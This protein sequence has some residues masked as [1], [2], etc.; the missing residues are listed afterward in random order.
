M[1]TAINTILNSPTVSTSPLTRRRLEVT[2][3]VVI[4]IA[5]VL[6]FWTQQRYPALLKRLHAGTG[7]KVQGVISFDALMK[8]TSDMPAPIRVFRTSVNW[9]Y[10]NRF[11]MYFALPFGAAI[12][13]LL[14]GSIAPKRFSSTAGNLLCGVV[15]GSPLG[16]C[17]NC[18]TP[19]AQ[20]LLVSG[21]STRLTVAAM[22]S[23]PSFN[24][25]VLIRIPHP[26]TARRFPEPAAHSDEGKP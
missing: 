7:V 2:L 17:T 19:V 1:S 24:P 9:I 10:T 14:A 13:S 20:S 23:S 8:V 22:I 21:A 3:S 25:V 4:A 15:A 16:V 5:V 11:G 6:I 18:A 26:P 12:M